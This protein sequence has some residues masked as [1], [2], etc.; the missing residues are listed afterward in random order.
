MALLWLSQA[1]MILSSLRSCVSHHW[2]GCWT[3]AHAIGPFHHYHSKE[4]VS[5]SIRVKC[6]RC[7]QG[8]KLSVSFLPHLTSLYPQEQMT[9]AELFIGTCVPEGLK[10]KL[11]LEEAG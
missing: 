5:A 6:T 2:E 9:Q 3:I 7:L 8:P 1:Y 4:P 10:E 11:G